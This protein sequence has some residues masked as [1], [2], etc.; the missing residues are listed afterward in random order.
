MDETVKDMETSLP[1]IFNG[2]SGRNTLNYSNSECVENFQKMCDAI[3]MEEVFSKLDKFEAE[4]KQ[5]QNVNKRNKENMQSAVNSAM[6]CISTLRM[7]E[8]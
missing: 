8:V 5:L 3:D 7:N 6:L 4:Y 2:L 1:R